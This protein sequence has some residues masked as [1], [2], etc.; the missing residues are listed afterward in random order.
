MLEID[1]I[2][3]FCSVFYTCRVADDAELRLG[4]KLVG[5]AGR[6]GSTPELP[7]PS[8]LET[9]VL[10]LLRQIEKVARKPPKPPPKPKLRLGQHGAG[11]MPH[12]VVHRPAPNA[13]QAASA[14][15]AAE[16]AESLLGADVL[17]LVRKLR[18]LQRQGADMD[19]SLVVNKTRKYMATIGK[20]IDTVAAEPAV[21]AE[22]W[23]YV[24]SYTENAMSGD[25]LEHV[26]R[27]LSDKHEPHNPS[28][29]V[30]HDA[31][32]EV[33][34]KPEP[35]AP[36]AAPEAAAPA[37]VA[38][39]PEHV[40]APA[41]EDV[42]DAGLPPLLAAAPAPVKEEATLLGDQT[43]VVQAPPP[44]PTLDPQA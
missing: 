12:T 7:K 40:P 20:R 9:R 21:R 24:S 44:P 35:V 37:I 11:P 36:A 26:Y 43:G 32:K 14:K 8:H 38:P 15:A 42:G 31:A 17:V 3:L 10:G 13:Q 33:G 22:L 34:P 2:C 23:A 1:A 39:K 5:A 6:E 41:G 18:T 27:R 30:G 28:Q 25:K 19:P 29:A 16:R 4:E